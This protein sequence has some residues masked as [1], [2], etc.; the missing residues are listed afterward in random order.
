MRC[1][2]TTGRPAADSFLIQP[3]FLLYDLTARRTEPVPLDS[4]LMMPARAADGIA[5]W[6]RRPLP[7]RPLIGIFG[8]RLTERST[9]RDH[10]KD[11]IDL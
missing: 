9:P 1:S 4:F 7:N 10:I 2:N 6:P 5:Y 3:P 8:K 11:H